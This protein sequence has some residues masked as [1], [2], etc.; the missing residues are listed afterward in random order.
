MHTSFLVDVCDSTS[1][2]FSKI[3]NHDSV[4]NCVIVFVISYLE[5][6]KST[7]EYWDRNISS[8][9]HAISPSSTA[10]ESKCYNF[11][12]HQERRLNKEHKRKLMVTTNGVS[13]L[14]EYVS[15]PAHLQELCRV[16]PSDYR[17]SFGFSK[18]NSWNTS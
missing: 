3:P 4:L 10:F 7:F 6:Q 2:L 14:E 18:A 15:F 5:L 1:A 13:I 16:N 12:P 17:L 11:G 8:Q 9:S